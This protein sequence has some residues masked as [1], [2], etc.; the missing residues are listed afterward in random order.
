LQAWA[1]V[2]N[3]AAFGTASY[4]KMGI[5]KGEKDR[6]GRG[7]IKEWANPLYNL[8]RFYN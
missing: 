7:N 2:A 1:K 4:T 5:I 3:V 8:G 6:K